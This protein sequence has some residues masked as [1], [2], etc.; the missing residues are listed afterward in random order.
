LSSVQNRAKTKI[1]ISIT[2][3]NNIIAE[4]NITKENNIIEDNNVIKKQH[5][6]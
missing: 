6:K 1:Q 4:N 2:E 5:N 3:E